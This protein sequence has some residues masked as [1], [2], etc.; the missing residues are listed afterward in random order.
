MIIKKNSN[1]DLVRLQLI[2]IQE[3]MKKVEKLKKKESENNAKD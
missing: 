3:L 1:E 2:V